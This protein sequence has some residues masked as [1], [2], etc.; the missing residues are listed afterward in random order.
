MQSLGI[1]IGGSGIKAA[2]VNTKTGALLTERIRVDTPIPATPENV[3]AALENLKNQISYSGPIG[4]GFPAAMATGTVLT[5]S[6]I[7]KSWIGVNIAKL[8]S[9]RLGEHCRVLNDAD[10][11]GTAEIHLG[12]PSFRKGTVIFITVGTGLGTALFHDGRLFPNSEL[13]HIQ[14]KKAGNA[15]KFASDA[16]RKKEKLSWEEWAERFNLYLRHL[17][18]LF[19]PQ[20]FILG[21]GLS[22]KADKVEN[23]IN[24]NT[25]VH[26]AS[27]QNH[28]GIIGAAFAARE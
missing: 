15:E 24:P 8:F 9:E 25:P 18:K 20:A 22:K 12:A 17:E 27:L 4:I 7:D 6:N 16:T 13:G 2:V 26:Y 1:D 28:A 3:V 21:G 10:A 19:W 23:L 14:L 11:A 5:A